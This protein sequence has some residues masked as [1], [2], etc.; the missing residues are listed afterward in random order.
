M[1]KLAILL[2]FLIPQVA[3][4][5]TPL[6]LPDEIE[7]GRSFIIDVPKY[8][9]DSIE[10]YFGDKQ[11]KFFEIQKKPNWDE[12]ISRAEFL[13]LLFDNYNFGIVDEPMT[14]NF[15]D[16][17]ENNPYRDYIRKAYTLGII[18]GYEDGNFGPYDPITRAHIAKILINAF[19]P[20]EYLNEI[21]EFPDVTEKDW[22][23]DFVNKAVKAKYFQGY[24]DGYMY[25]NRYINYDE[26]KIVITRA[27]IPKEFIEIENKAYY[28]GFVGIH[29]LSEAGPINVKIVTDNN[30]D[31]EI[32]VLNRQYPT[33]SF[34]LE[35]SKNELFASDK[36]DNTWDLI[37]GAKS[38]TNPEQLWEGDFI[39]PTE[40]IITLGFG[41]TLYINGAFSGSHFGLDYANKVGTE[42]IAS[43]NGIITLAE[44]T[45]SYG[46]TVIIDHGQNIFTMYL[47]C[48][49]L[50]VQKGDKVNKG[51]LIATMGSTGI[52]TGSHLHFT[53]FIGDI[54][55]DNYEWYD[56]KFL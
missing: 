6:R 35:P 39:K 26:A 15:P 25:P 2:L 4:A 31:Y 28:R 1:K 33:E 16:V 3:F 50:K 40:G 7:R 41:D 21:F 30:D 44:E 51:D 56:G 22:F 54:I 9:N 24:P 32:N 5:N 19:E 27:A 36:I 23:Y 29:R 11:I 20:P 45:M 53:V 48:N 14:K 13:K 8:E 34:Y 43:N 52:A 38:N 46:N 12:Y 10:G 17:T 37:N 42:I 55:V 47:H 18:D 49:E